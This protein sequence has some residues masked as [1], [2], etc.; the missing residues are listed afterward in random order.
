MAIKDLLKRER[1][2]MNKENLQ[3]LAKMKH[4]ITKAAVLK[5]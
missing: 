5:R 3:I 4:K 1:V 2:Q